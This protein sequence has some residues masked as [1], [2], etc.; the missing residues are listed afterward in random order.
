MAFA[1]G[2]VRPPVARRQHP[3]NI[4]IIARRP[5]RGAA[6]WPYHS[7]KSLSIPPQAVVTFPVFSTGEGTAGDGVLIRS[8]FPRGEGSGRAGAQEFAR[9]SG[10]YVDGCQDQAERPVAQSA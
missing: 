4:W 1:H 7:L 8:D 2:A 5:R 9:E 3:G 10:Q 6:I